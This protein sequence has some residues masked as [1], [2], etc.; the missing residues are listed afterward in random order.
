[1][2]EEYIL[3]HPFVNTRTPI[4]WAL[5]TAIAIYVAA[6]EDCKEIVYRFRVK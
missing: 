4:A 5:L 6:A 3:Q 1:M 2:I